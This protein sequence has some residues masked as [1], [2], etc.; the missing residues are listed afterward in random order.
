MYIK[1][2]PKQIQEALPITYE[3]NTDKN[4]L[5]VTF[6]GEGKDY[7]GQASYA[8]FVD[9]IKKIKMT[10]LLDEPFEKIKN[11]FNFNDTELR[12]MIDFSKNQLNRI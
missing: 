3:D 8:E 1:M 10:N 5:T 11:D 12:N 6:D 4:Y 7:L 2:S 9:Y